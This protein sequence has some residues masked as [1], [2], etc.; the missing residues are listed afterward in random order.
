M[1]NERIGEDETQGISGNQRGIFETEWDLN[2]K[3]DKIQG[4]KRSK[5]IK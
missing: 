4:K 2:K 5:Y 1:K 3:Y